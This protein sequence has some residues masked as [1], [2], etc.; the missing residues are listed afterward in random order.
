[1]GSGKT[2]VGARVAG[3]A[4]VEFV[5]L[6]RAVETA[7]G[8]SVA[9]IFAAEGEQSF[10]DAEREVFATVL[11]G[12]RVI[13]LGGGA[14]M[15]DAIWRRVKAEAVSVFLEVPLNVMR[16]R[17][18]AGTGRPL[19][20]GDLDALLAARVARYREADH[21]VDGSQAAD[22]VAQEVLRLWSG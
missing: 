21:T 13:A 17:L 2:T 5:D 12:G 18:G 3:L 19:A 9:E 10:R 6:D 20:G 7:R 11:A 16:E 15:Q 14:P 22:D 1:M 8:Q 4:G